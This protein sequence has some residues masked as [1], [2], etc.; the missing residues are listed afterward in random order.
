MGA[1]LSFST[2]TIRKSDVNDPGCNSVAAANFVAVF[3]GAAEVD[4]SG[5]S[6]F[7]LR[8]RKL[9]D[10]RATKVELD[11][12]PMSS[13][14]GLSGHK[15]TFCD[16]KRATPPAASGQA[17]TPPSKLMNSRRF[18]AAPEINDRTSYRQKLVFWKGSPCPLW[19][20]SRQNVPPR[21]RMSAFGRKADIGPTCRRLSGERRANPIGR[22]RWFMDRYFSAPQAA[23]TDC[24][25]RIQP[26]L[27]RACRVQI[28][29]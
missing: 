25:G 29:R 15:L 4:F 1:Q 24:T 28:G 13:C 12:G 7:G 3:I 27:P 17:E 6:H 2:G 11:G 18:I 16:V 20:I 14:Y 8:N 10:Y 19:V 26:S 5:S 21:P 22:H 23:E 9:F